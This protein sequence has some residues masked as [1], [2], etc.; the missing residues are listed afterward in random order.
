MMAAKDKKG[1]KRLVCHSLACGYEESESRD[2]SLSHRPSKREKAV[3]SRL[4]QKYS[5]HSTETSSFG[6]L[7]KASME[8]KNK[9]SVN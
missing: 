5:D 6:D 1:R 7:I 4:V 2:G 8:R 9:D 3:T